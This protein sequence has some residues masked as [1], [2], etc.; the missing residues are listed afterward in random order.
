M[1]AVPQPGGVLSQQ[2]DDLADRERRHPRRR[3]LDS[4]RHAIEK[5]CHRGDLVEQGIIGDQVGANT[6]GTIE[7]QL[8]GH[9]ASAG[10]QWCDVDDL[11]V[12]HPQC[13]TA[14]CEHRGSALPG[15]VLGDRR[16]GVD[17]VLA[18]VEHDDR[19]L[20]GQSCLNR[21]SWRGGGVA[22]ERRSNDRIDVALVRRNSQVNEARRVRLVRGDR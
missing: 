21:R 12:G 15:K 13:R 10:R 7:E 22:A 17:D 18:V 14:G 19:R 20:G 1:A 16:C 8:A 5:L 6:P 11:L 4:E 2:M 3:Q 9:A